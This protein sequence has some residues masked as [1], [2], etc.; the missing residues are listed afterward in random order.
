M[1]VTV[2]ARSFVSR[3]TFGDM[4]CALA[5]S[6]HTQKTRCFEHPAF[7]QPYPS[8]TGCP[9]IKFHHT[10]PSKTPLAT[11]L[12]HLYLQPSRSSSKPPCQHPKKTCKPSSSGPPT[13]AHTST[14]PSV[15]MPV[16]TLPLLQR[17]SAN[18]SSNSQR[19]CLRNEGHRTRHETPHLSPRTRLRL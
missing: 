10:T 2:D 18:T 17:T 12:A 8:T 19:A 14:L 1:N 9:R 7:L 13:M 6:S 11:Y 3:V 4:R 16:R 5:V 15:S